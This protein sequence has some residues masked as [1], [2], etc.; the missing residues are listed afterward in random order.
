MALTLFHIADA[1]CAQKVRIALA[2]KSLAWDS[3]IVT[4]L[5]S[6]DYLSLNPNGYVP[7][8][9]HDDVTLIESRI[10][11]EYIEDAFAGASLLP[12][13]PFGRYRARKW[14]KQVDDAL[15]LAIYTL[16]FAIVFR[17]ARLKMSEEA[18]RDAL[19]LTNPVK[20][21]YTI[22]LVDRGLASPHFASAVDRFV[23]LLGEMDNALSVSPWLAGDRYSLA[24]CDLTP[25]L[26]RLRRLGLLPLLLPSF[27]AVS[28]W[29]D[30]VEARPSFASGISDWLSGDDESRT[31]TLVAR[32]QG[33]VEHIVADVLASRSDGV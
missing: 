23:K 32:S 29:F 27:P 30:A 14:T 12:D 18:R 9:V 31:K 11:S 8:L 15:H 13:D 21:A 6:A 26:A 20:R 1:I 25:Y 5:R 28:R 19:P 33:D 2:E 22:D 4:D 24:D 3:R 17:E 10:I 7:T 16:S